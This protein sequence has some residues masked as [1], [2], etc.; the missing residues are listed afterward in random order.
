MRLRASALEHGERRARDARASALRLAEHLPRERLP[1]VLA[2]H[3]LAMLLFGWSALLVLVGGG[4]LFA[5]LRQRMLARLGG[6][7]GDT[8]GAMVEVAECTAL[9][10]VALLA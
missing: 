1:V 2:G 6:T 9:V 5:W 4:L 8:A 3:A 7:T 10:L